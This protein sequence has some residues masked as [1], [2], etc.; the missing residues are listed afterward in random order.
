MRSKRGPTS[1]V[2]LP[3]D[4]LLDIALDHLSL[5]R[6]HL[7]LALTSGASPDFAE[8]AEHLDRA[9]DGLR[10]SGRDDCLPWGLLARTAL[11]RFRDAIDAAA[12]DLGDV[13]EIAGRG[14]M[15]LHEA[16]VHLEWTRLRLRTGDG[17]AARD[18]FEKA[19][20]I[21]TSTVDGRREREVA[22]L[23]RVLTDS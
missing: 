17:Q 2:A 11:H 23:D 9:V 3:A 1:P 8:A 20:E 21:V 18:H 14:H 10:Q 7:G 22:W 15:R 6:A 4:P 13:E 16:D 12:A 5:G 19:R